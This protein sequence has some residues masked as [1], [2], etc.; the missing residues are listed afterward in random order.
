VLVSIGG[1]R[2]LTTPCIAVIIPLF[3]VVGAVHFEARHDR[4]RNRKRPTDANR[5][6]KAIGEEAA[7]EIKPDLKRE[8]DPAAVSLGRR[9]GLKGGKSRAEK[10]SA[11]RRVEIASRA[12]R[13]RWDKS[14]G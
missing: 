12:A 4:S 11:A 6:V 13:A 5:L 2:A 3:K 9:G 8:K 10:L 1:G 7:R 14:S